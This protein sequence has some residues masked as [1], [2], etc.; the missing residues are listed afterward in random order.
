M[1]NQALAG[2]IAGCTGRPFM[3]LQQSAT[4]GGCINQAFILQ[5]EDGRRFFVKHNAAA[6]LAMFEAEAAALHELA[7]CGAIRVPQVIGTT[8]DGAHAYLVMEAISFGR[9]GRE[10]DA[11]LGRELAALHRHR[12]SQF[13]WWRDNTIGSTPQ[14]NRQHHD[15]PTFWREQRLG[16]QLRLL[17]A[18]GYDRRVV[19]RGERLC[20]RLEGLF[21]GYSP[22]PSL[23]HGDLWSGNYGF[24]SAGS[25][26]LFDP[27]SY[28]GDREADL[29]M[30]ELFG[31][32]APAFYQAY[33]E[34]WPLDPGYRI[35]KVLYNLYHIL[36][37]VNLFGTGYLG[38]AG[39]MTEQLLA[40]LG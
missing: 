8:T 9:A 10:G 19:E 13:G 14:P 6:R 35:R 38:Q 40:E 26:V 1:P 29:A 37:H 31:G 24:D 12:A 28:Y 15:W 21:D 30:T 17:A 3:P 27:A 5:G 36:N 25:P 16:H 4:A 34:A 11:R 32:F 7:G 39:R 2:L 23:L 18:N 22:V 33:A 20:A